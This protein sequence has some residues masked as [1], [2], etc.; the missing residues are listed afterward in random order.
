MKPYLITI[1][2]PGRPASCYRGI[3]PH[4]IDAWVHG[5]DT[6]GEPNARITARP[7]TLPTSQAGALRLE[8][9]GLVFWLAISAAL[10]LYTWAYAT[11]PA[12][13]WAQWQ[14]AVRQAEQVHQLQL[15]AAQARHSE[16]SY[17]AWVHGHCGPET[18]WK[19]RADGALA[20]TDKRGRS[21]GQVLVEAQP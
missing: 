16:R 8:V 10:L 6:C 3:F 1:R 17:I 9:L 20:C 12:G 19:P 15:S 11:R 4:V 5:L 13:P 21:T 18:W 2:A 14:A 7:I